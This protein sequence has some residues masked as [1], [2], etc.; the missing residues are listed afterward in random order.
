MK[1]FSSDQ[2]KTIDKY[3]IKHEPISSVNLME[4]ASQNIFSKISELCYKGSEFVV[5]ASSGNNGGDGLAVARL[6]H[7]AGYSVR[8][9]LVQV[10]G[11]LSGDCDINF[12]RLTEIKKIQKDVVKHVSEINFSN[13]EIIIDALFGSGLSRPVEKLA[14][15]IVKKINSS[16]CRVI[17]IDLPSGL[18][19]DDN[20][21][22]N[23]E[24][25]VKADYTLSLQF[26]KISFFFSENYKYTGEW[27]VLPI[28][29]HPQIISEEYSP[30][31]YLEDWEIKPLL[32]K[33]EKFSH[34]GN[35]GHALIIS[36]SYGKMGAA[37]LVSRACMRAGAGLLTSYIPACGYNIMQISS[38]E[39]MVITDSCQKYVSELPDVA[40]YSAIGIGPGI[41]THEL[42]GEILKKLIESVRVP[43]IIDAD[44][45]NLLAA[46]KK[47]L[48]NLPENT[49][50]TPHPKEFDRLAGESSTSF[51][52]F[53]R[54]ALFSKRYKTIVVLKGAYT[55]IFSPD[56][57]CF[58]NSTG[59][60]GMATGGS[61]DVLTGI[62]LG[63]L[64][65]GYKP[66]NAAKIG[67]YIH[68]LS[69]DMAA[70]IT[71]QYSLTASQIVEY[72]P[73]AFKTL[74]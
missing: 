63:L 37:V 36:G 32:K 4:R 1:L 54:A 52:R 6:L 65:Q 16:G 68:G 64:A 74:V 25:I 42:T 45:L 2:I 51:E 18:F 21:G 13:R 29:L 59:N 7:N 31:I 17:S 69:G 9:I 41:G 24:G 60:P 39:S 11:K 50:L 19:C 30:F 34:K 33:R 44:G 40:P 61:G 27:F 43:L 23:P 66:V 22:N 28:G 8:V 53:K 5:V 56:G 62:I 67:V 12:N 14:L 72:L 73:S 55:Q 38:P 70:S 57:N 20:S 58:F 15:E 48:R 49:I 35:F 71:G 3:T 47:W 26:P 46:N 10:S